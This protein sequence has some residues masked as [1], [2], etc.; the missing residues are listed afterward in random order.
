MA[1]YKDVSEFTVDRNTWDR[2]RGTSFLL[3][4]N[5]EKM[6]CL[7]FY[8]RACRLKNKEIEFH[9]SPWMLY[10]KWKTFLINDDWDNSKV[11]KKLMK[12]NDDEC[13]SADRREKQLK[14]IFKAN[15][16]KVKFKG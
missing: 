1:K 14:K 8:A 3:N 12:V 6:C 16:V 5:T 2:G 7:G 11:C 4:P 13:M 15:G 9:G 10:K